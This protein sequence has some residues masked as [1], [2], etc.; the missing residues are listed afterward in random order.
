MLGPYWENL[1]P[2]EGLEPGERAVLFDSL[3]KS[4]GEEEQ[5]EVQGHYYSCPDVLGGRPG[6]PGGELGLKGGTDG[7]KYYIAVTHPG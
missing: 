4:P 7:K 3:P 1:L 6:A 5:D 2:S